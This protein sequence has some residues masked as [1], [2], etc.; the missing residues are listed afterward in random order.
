MRLITIVVAIFTMNSN[1]W[2]DTVKR[3]EPDMTMKDY[4]AANLEHCL[5]PETKTM[6]RLEPVAPPPEV[7]GRVIKPRVTLE[8]LC[9][10][11]PAFRSCQTT[12]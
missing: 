5:N 8:E 7:R 3:I 2:A 1:V 9:A 4:C 11:D 6:R 12:L 10:T